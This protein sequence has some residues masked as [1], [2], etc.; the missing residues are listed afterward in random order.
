MFKNVIAKSKSTALAVLVGLGAAMAP[1]ANAAGTAPDLSSLTS[2]VDFSTTI[3]A[4]LA[5]SGLLA[6]VY[7]AIKGAKTV[8]RM[9]KGG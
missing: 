6:G 4:L 9:I 8:L 5:I 3:T 2:A 1:A 7:I